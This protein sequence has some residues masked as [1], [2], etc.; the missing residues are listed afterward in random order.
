MYDPDRV[1]RLA[2]ISTKFH[3]HAAVGDE[4][5]LGID[6]DDQMPAKYRGGARPTGTIVRIKNEGSENSTL[7]VQME[8]SG[9]MVD[10]HPYTV[11]GDRVWEFTDR[12]WEKVLA[13]SNPQAAESKYRGSAAG[14]DDIFAMR[15]QMTEM[16]QRFDRE[17]AESKNFNN[18]LVESIA[19]ITSDIETA[20]P[21]KS[22][23]SAVF[24]QEF[25][26]MQKNREASPFDSDMESGDEM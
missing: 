15:K 19:Q 22:K 16:S 10:L 18:A 24:N 12:A 25:R 17:M 4:V 23:F 11:A 6:G 21:G 26:S 8:G 13:R 9:R 20:N 7:R 14:N 2:Q 3:A 1:S 5:H